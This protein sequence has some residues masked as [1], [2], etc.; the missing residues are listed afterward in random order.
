MIT[1]GCPTDSETITNIFHSFGV[2]MR[3]LGLVI[4]QF[5]E[6]CIQNNECF[7][8]MDYLLEKEIFLRSIKH[9]ILNLISNCDI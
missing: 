1:E 6:K 7:N 9:V 3:Y 8:H 2:N 5:R 4:N